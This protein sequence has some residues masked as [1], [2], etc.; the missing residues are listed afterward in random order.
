MEQTLNLDV[1]GGNTNLIHIYCCR[2]LKLS[3]CS[4]R[5]ILPLGF[6][7]EVLMSESLALLEIN[8]TDLDEFEH[9]AREVGVSLTAEGRT[10]ALDGAS[11]VAFSTA[12]IPP[13]LAVLEVL[14]KHWLNRRRTIRVRVGNTF[15]EADSP[16]DLARIMNAMNTGD[17]DD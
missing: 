7:L 10:D 11:L 14:L 13:L 6:K 9:L 5:L 16:N 2:I 1:N 17:G 4:K 3:F 8:A 12:V 15:I